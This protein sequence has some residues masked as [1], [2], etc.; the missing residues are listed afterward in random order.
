MVSAVDPV[1]LGP[2]MIGITCAWFSFVFWDGMRE[3]G[4]PRRATRRREPGEPGPWWTNDGFDDSQCAPALV[5][6]Q[7]RSR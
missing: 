2:L 3:D 1:V 6:T 4:T 7:A 5:E